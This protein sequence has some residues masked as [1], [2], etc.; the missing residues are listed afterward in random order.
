[1]FADLVSNKAQ[2]AGEA[3]NKEGTSLVSKSNKGT[4]GAPS[5]AMTRPARAPRSARGPSQPAELGA[6]AR[7]PRATNTFQ[8]AKGKGGG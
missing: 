2:R 5:E 7:A 8:P 4:V 3:Y 1:M 6:R